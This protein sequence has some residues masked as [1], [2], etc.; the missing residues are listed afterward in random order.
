MKPWLLTDLTRLPEIYRLRALAWQ[1][2][3]YGHL[4]NTATHPDG[5]KDALDAGSL[6]FII[7]DEA[8]GIIAAVRYSAFE[9]MTHLCEAMPVYKVLSLSPAGPV[10]YR[11]RLVVHPQWRGSGLVRRLDET[12]MVFFAQSDASVLFTQTVATGQP[13]LTAMGFRHLHTFPVNL[14]TG[15]IEMPS[16]VFC[17][18]RNQP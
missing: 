16:A 18:E 15:S 2:S 3:P 13:S 8:G 11:A 14:T 7:E 17:C 4:L 5:L 10:A 9:S 6:H 1:H 12:L